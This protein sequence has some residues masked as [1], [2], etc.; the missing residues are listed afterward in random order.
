M[1]RKK[2]PVWG[3]ACS[4]RGEIGTDEPKGSQH[5]GNQHSPWWVHSPETRKALAPQYPCPQMMGEGWREV[6]TPV[7]GG[8]FT[9]SVSDL[10]SVL[11][12]G[13]H[14]LLPWGWS[15]QAVSENRAISVLLRR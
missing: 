3:L 6:R 2:L 13:A 1:S 8:L 7:C 12:P 9:C 15:E 10:E 5:K 14:G 4:S 11:L